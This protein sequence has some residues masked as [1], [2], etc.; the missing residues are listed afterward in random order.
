M[1]AAVFSCT[2]I[3]TLPGKNWLLP[4]WSPCVCVLTM[5]VTGLSVTFFTSS[6][7]AWPLSASLV[8][9]SSTPFAMTHT[10]VLPP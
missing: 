5:W 10:A 1:L 6:R 9:T 3:W 8:S 4:V 7:M 2:T